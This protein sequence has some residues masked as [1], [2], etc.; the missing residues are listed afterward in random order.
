MAS[1]LFRKPADRQMGLKVLAQGIT[2]GGKSQFGLGFPKIF[3]LDS[4]TGLAF[5]E[6]DSPNLL[7]IANTQD[8]NSIQTALKEVETLV[9]KEAGS[10]GTLLIDSETK[11]YQN[12]TDTALSVEEKKARKAGRDVNDSAISMRGW[13]RIKSVAQRLQNAKLDLSAKGVHIVSVAQLE[14]VKEKQGESFVKVGDKAVMQKGSEYDY[15]L[16]LHFYTEEE[17]EDT[18]YF[19]KVLKDRTKTFKK[20]TIIE[21][22]SFSMWEGKVV[23]K[24]AEIIES[25]FAGDSDK[26]KASYE[27]EDNAIQSNVDKFK[28]LMKDDSKKSKALELLKTHK[29]K[30]PLAP[31][32]DEE[33]KAMDTIVKELEK[34]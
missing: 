15:D 1:S 24:D 28:E 22:A 27:E 23:K 8:Y 6:N 16:I 4:E 21:N 25:D 29:V 14:D 32:T 7:G 12:L 31:K 20:G 11:F 19:A 10:I 2:G 9:K 26:A 33:I 5:Y 13:G 18:R 30:N 17:G 3:A 34:L